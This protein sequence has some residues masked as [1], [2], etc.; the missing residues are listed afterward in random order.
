MATD[1][2]DPGDRVKVVIDRSG[3]PQGEFAVAVGLDASKMSKSLA[4]ARRFTSLDLAAIAEHGGVTVDWLLTGREAPVSMA[5]RAASGSSSEQAVKQAER[6]AELRETAAELGYPQAWTGVSLPDSKI[7]MVDQ[8][9]ALAAEALD[10]V[11]ASGLD[12]SVPDLAGLV[13]RVFGAD[14]CIVDLGSGFDG[15][16]VVTQEAKAIVAAPTPQAYRQRF[17]IAHELAHLLTGDDQGVHLDRDV[18]ART[19]DETEWRANAFAA[20]FLMPE[21][22]LRAAGALTDGAFCRLASALRVS[23]AALAIRLEGLRLIDAM[24]RDQWRTITAKAAAARAGCSAELAESSAYS[25]SPRT[26][27]LLLRDLMQAHID[28]RTTLRPAARLLDVDT[29]SL[30]EELARGEAELF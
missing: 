20:A 26:P 2:P 14:V 23:P 5:A 11:A 19:R 1:S 13:E 10:L 3:L 24:A 9:E 22:E 6:V 8:G 21:A 7:R 4:G 29:E 25:M 16:S 28:E 27:A 12:A 15:L 18:L 17:T 30:R